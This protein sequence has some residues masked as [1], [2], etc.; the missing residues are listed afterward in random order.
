MTEPLQQ[1]S[2][3]GDGKK[4]ILDVDL[5]ECN[6]TT[7]L[8]LT[9]CNESTNYELI[10]VNE[11]TNLGLINSNEPTNLVAHYTGPSN[12][13]TRLDLPWSS[14]G[15]FQI[16]DQ[17]EQVFHAATSHGALTYFSCDTDPAKPIV[18]L[19]TLQPEGQVR[20]QR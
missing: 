16:R 7:N 14:Q 13:T 10:E 3:Y 9:E 4:I 12:E 20:G 17:S 8:D 11:S 2:V 15:I 18:L 6:E 5:I 1:D 19:N